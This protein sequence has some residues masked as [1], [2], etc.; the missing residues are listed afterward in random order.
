MFRILF[1]VVL[2]AVGFLLLKSWQRR[3]KLKH[4]Q[5]QAK[6]RDATQSSRMVR[7]LYC[8]LHVPENEAISQG[9]KHFCSLEHATHYLTKE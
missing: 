3:Q 1:V 4:E 2:L 6:L 9:G 8:G 5:Q 7:C